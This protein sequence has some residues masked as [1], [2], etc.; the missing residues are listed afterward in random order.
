MAPPV[1]APHPRTAFRPAVYFSILGV[2]AII[3]A[4]VIL[5]A[6]PGYAIARQTRRAERAI[7]SGH[8]DEAIPHLEAIVARYP[9]AWLRQVQLGDCLLDLDKGEEALAAFEASLR[10]NPEQDL[11]SR[12]GRALY[13][14][15]PADPR[16]PALLE[17]ALAAD[18]G[19]PRAHFYVALS[20][21][22]QGRYRDAATHLLGATADPRWLERARPHIERNR[23]RLLGR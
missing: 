15:D 5:I 4:S 13:L 12:M 16:G 11:R 20:C 10:A 2:F 1:D 23:I 17:E 8:A 18:P 6:W 19:D 14:L 22:D 7:E 9:G 21:E 3:S